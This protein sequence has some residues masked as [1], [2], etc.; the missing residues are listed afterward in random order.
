MQARNWIIPFTLAS[1]WAGI[2]PPKGKNAI[3]IKNQSPEVFKHS[4]TWGIQK[5]DEFSEVL[6]DRILFI[7]AWN[8]WA[9][10]N[11]LEPCIQNGYS[12]LEKVKEVFG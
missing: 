5:L 9:E 6:D 4:L 12:Y 2:I 10:G 8:E 11:Y 3:V 1:W 7:N